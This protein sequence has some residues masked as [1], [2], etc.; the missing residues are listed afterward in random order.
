MKIFLI[1]VLFSF[2][3]MII[4]CS[5]EDVNIETMAESLELPV[6][7]NF[8]DE[9]PLPT[10]L[11]ATRYNEHQVLCSNTR[12]FDEVG[13]KFKTLEKGIVN[14]LIVKIPIV[15]SNLIVTLTDSY[16][17]QVIRTESLN[18]ITA[19]TPTLKNIVP[20]ELEK[21]KTYYITMRT[22][23]YYKRFRSDFS[24]PQY[25]V[26]VGSITIITPVTTAFSPDGV[27]F[28]GSGNFYSGDCSFTF[29]RTE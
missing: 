29:L 4:S 24:Q 1:P 2:F 19:N 16:S 21:N 15:N 22:N 25:P 3:L 23:N 11:S 10:F 18:V 5:N 17:N 8:T 20:L 27:S 7:T 12:V 14:S 9:N 13:F 28:G 26:S 6:D